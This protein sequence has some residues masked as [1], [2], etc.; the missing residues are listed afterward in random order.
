MQTS[1]VT[2][3]PQQ[4]EVRPPLTL[5]ALAQLDP[6]AL[7]ELFAGGDVDDD[8]TA[9]SGHPRGRVLAAPALRA[10]LLVAALRWL[11]ASPLILWEGKSFQAAE[12]A[13][14]GRG[15]NRARL[16]GRA[17]LFPFRTW[18][19]RSVVDGR[20]CLV[21][22]YDVPRNP[23]VLRPVYDEVRRI[24]PELYLGR[25]CYRRRGRA[26]RPVLWFALD[27]ARQD[28]PLALPLPGDGA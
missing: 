26:A 20:P 16:K 6:S 13:A 2:E 5:E 23:P 24:G 17:A 14:R 12:G 25:G 18:I 15:A 4:A 1:T 28:R 10:R 21:I 22:S 27:A 3:G 9:M 19:D 7:A 8:L 11:A